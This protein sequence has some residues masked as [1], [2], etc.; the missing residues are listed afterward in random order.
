MKKI[1]SFIVVSLF[2][3]AFAGCGNFDELNHNPNLPDPKEHPDYNFDESALGSVFRRSVPAVEGDD[4]QRIKSLMV[5]FYAQMLD[6]GQ[7]D[8]KYY[9]MN[10]DWNS[11][12]F[13][14][15]Q[16]PVADLNIIIRGCL[17]VGGENENLLAVAKIWRVY[18][19]S[20]GVDVFGPLPFAGY[21]E[22]ENNPPYKSVQDSYTE[23]FAELE[24]ASVMLTNGSKNPVFNNASF[25]VIFNND[26]NKWLKFANSLRLRLALRLSEIAPEVCK[27]QAT[28]ALALGVMESAGD[29]AWLPPKADGGWG[30]DYNYTMFQITW[31]GPLKMTASIYKLLANI[32]GIDFPE[33]IVNRR[34]QYNTGVAT[35]VSTHPDK[36]DPRGP[37]MFDPA[38]E[39]GAWAGIPYGIPRESAGTGIYRTVLWAELGTLIKGGAP[40]KTRPYDLML[41]EEIC[42]LKAEVALRGFASGDAKSEYEKGVRASFAT[43][44][45]ADKADA[46]LASNDK[47]LAGTSAD[48]DDQTRDGNT[49]LEKIITQKYLALF[50]DMSMESWS[51]KRRLNLPRMDVSLYRD[52]LLYSSS[53]KNILDPA[54]FIKRI[55]YPQSETQV[56]KAEYDKGVQLLGGSDRCNTK[57][58]WDANKNY[59]T[60][61]E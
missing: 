14:R 56:N 61:S 30:N 46:Y 19:Q 53:N 15:I 16:I 42:F 11:R 58:W 34:A 50:P 23:F 22:V 35:P 59:C 7:F 1:K 2:L 57:I 49:A 45:V 26:P 39:G 43:W 10:D 33:G 25:V 44:G 28:R 52:E 36:V 48:Y 12:F 40:Y 32:G 21:K 38:Y 9:L 27:T 37:V 24:E 13:R 18:V 41:F 55:Q 5:D 17:E 6:G 20:I 29:N 4:E 8:T 31:G 54:N 3:F 47:N 51:D 60:S